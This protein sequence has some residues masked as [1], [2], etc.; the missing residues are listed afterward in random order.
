[1]GSGRIA[2]AGAAI[3]GF[4]LVPYGLTMLQEGMGGVAAQMH[5]SDLPAAIGAPGVGWLSGWLGL[6]SQVVIGLIMTAVMQSSTAAI[7][8]TLAA[9]HAGAVGPDQGCALIIGQN[10]GTAN[11]SAMAAIG[12]TTTAKRLAVAYILFKI[13]A[14]LIAIFSFPFV[15]PLIA[16][17]SGVLD[18]VTLLAAYHNTYNVVGVA[19]LMPFIERFTRFVERLLPET[20]SPLTGSLDPAALENPIVAVDAVRRTIAL[21]IEAMRPKVEAAVAADEKIGGLSLAEPVEALRQARDFISDVSGPPHCDN[22]DA[23]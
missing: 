18:G 8:I 13:I 1:M 5:P 17:F 6:M 7:A 15:I 16:R 21:A 14:A 23:A 10:I 3:A 19:A 22:E 20:R 12:A 2:A 9:F 11:S 4:A